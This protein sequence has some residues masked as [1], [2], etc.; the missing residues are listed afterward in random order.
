MK[1]LENNIVDL[2]DARIETRGVDVEGPV[3]FQT[4]LKIRNGG[5]QAD[6]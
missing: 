3:D 5:I 4:L 6:D 1:T 2:G